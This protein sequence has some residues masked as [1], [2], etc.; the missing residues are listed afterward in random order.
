M[1]LKSSS[2][3]AMEKRVDLAS[4]FCMI[5]RHG[6]AVAVAVMAVVSV[7]AGF[8]IYRNVREKR[9]KAAAGAADSD[10]RSPGAQSDETPARPEESRRREE[11][12][13]V[14]EGLPNTETDADVTQSNRKV[15]NR[16][17]AKKKHPSSP[18]KSDSKLDEDHASFVQ[19]TYNVRAQEDNEDPPGD[20]GIVDVNVKSEVCRQDVTGDMVEEAKEDQ[21]VCLKLPVT[22][23]SHEEKVSNSEEEENVTTDEDVLG[24]KPSREEDPDCVS[25]S[26]DFPD[27]TPEVTLNK[28][29][30]DDETVP[31]MGG[32]ESCMEEPII[33]TDL[34]ISSKDA[35]VKAENLHPDHTVFSDQDGH[36]W[37][38]SEKEM[39]TEEQGGCVDEQM[40]FPQHEKIELSFEQ[41]SKQDQ[42][43]DVTEELTASAQD[44]NVPQLRSEKQENGPTS[45]QEDGTEKGRLLSDCSEAHDTS[46]M[47]PCFSKSLKPDQIDVEGLCA[48]TSNAKA[49]ISGSLDLSGFSDHLQPENELR[50]EMVTDLGPDSPAP[51]ALDLTETQS[52]EADAILM[53]AEGLNHLVSTS[54]QSPDAAVCEE[55]SF[56]APV[57]ATAL[58]PADVFSSFQDQKSDTMPSTEDLP[59]ADSGPA[60]DTAESIK[61]SVHFQLLSFDQCEPTWS[62]SGVGEESGISSMTVSPDLQDPDKC[63]VTLSVMDHYPK[64]EEHTEALSR[65][66][67]KEAL[68]VTED[69]A[70]LVVG[71]IL[72]LSEQPHCEQTDGADKFTATKDMFGHEDGH[73]GE[74]GQFAINV[75]T[76]DGCLTE[77][78]KEMVTKAEAV[79]STTD[80][81]K[82]AEKDKT[83]ISIMEAT[84]DNNEWITDGNYQAL[85]WMNL[86]IPPLVQNAHVEHHSSIPIGDACTNAD[87]PPSTEVKQTNIL[88]HVDENSE[89]GK[90]VVAVQPMPQNVNVTFRTHYFTNSPYQKVAITGNQQELGNWKEFV[91]LERA[92]DGLWAT[93]VGLPVECHVEWKFVVLDKGEVCRWEECGNR[94]LDTGNGDDLVVHKWWGSL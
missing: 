65:F 55:T 33:Q 87:D 38:P 26:P 6:P 57:M 8:I 5:G 90:K 93:V 21:D 81:Q 42:T 29:G 19:G 64:A 83:E 89:N 49:Q 32:N 4:L 14:S 40:I 54:S 70:G 2:S 58:P 7:L 25:N 88:P 80:E 69:A 15:R 94:L 17:A 30:Q 63:D 1:Q 36:N 37:L 10:G 13:D 66:F 84:M 9:R 73:P 34:L 92:K 35:E 60:P 78:K 22:R 59:E 46:S 39:K 72:Q 44:G 75:P 68:S 20:S 76:S 23:E 56:T 18:P 77:L 86:S 53:L 61:P 82:V 43:E 52:N 85:P 41:T 28:D 50:N 11:A 47:V 91:P 16:R 24:Q 51:E 3:V 31:A 45:D 67:N 74:M 27:E 62:S 79:E 48:P 12:T 71:S